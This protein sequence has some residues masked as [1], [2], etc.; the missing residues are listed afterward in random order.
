MH[1]DKYG[2]IGQIQADGS[3]EGGDSACWMGHWIYLTDED[4]PYVETFEKGFGGYVRHPDPAQTNNGF[5]AH[6][7]NPWNGCISRDQLTGIIGALIKRKEK[8]ALLRLIIHHAAWGFLWSYNNIKNGRDP[9]TAKWKWPDFTLMN[10]WASYLRG[11]GKLSWL[12]WPLLCLLDIHILGD[13]IYTRFWS[14][15]DDQINHALKLFISRDYVPTPTS[16]LAAKLT[17]KNGLKQKLRRYWGGWRDSKEFIPYYERKID[18][19]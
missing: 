4:F 13:A 9:A 14:K 6:Y 16:W 19:L 3:V 15:S 1:R 5:G 2:I 17:D 7:K 11:F 8:R 10:I 12:A 18:E